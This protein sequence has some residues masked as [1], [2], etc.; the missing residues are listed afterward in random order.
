MTTNNTPAFSA[1]RHI[2]LV[3]TA[4]LIRAQLKAAFPGQKFSVT[5]S[6]FP[7]GTSADV[8]WTDGP[9]ANQV[10][11]VVAPFA[12]S[13]FDG[14]IDLGVSVQSWYCP[15]HGASVRACAGTV[16]SR[17]C[18]PEA[19]TVPCCLA[20]EPVAFGAKYVGT[21]RTLSDDFKA[22]LLDDL[23]VALGV[24][25]DPSGTLLAWVDRDGDIHGSDQRE[26]VSTLV[27]Q[28]AGTTAVTPE[29]EIVRVA[30]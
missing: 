23:A 18:I 25:V 11:A 22:L 26:Y 6:R 13:R 9:T 2:D 5:T 1:P 14:S 20:G 17:G 4:K 15:E 8:S 27:H 21:S 3:E 7:M 24:E 16:D 30:R 10:E 12:S 28:L 29:R 19:D